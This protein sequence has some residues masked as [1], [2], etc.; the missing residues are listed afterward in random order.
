MD[1]EIEFKDKKI[2]VL[3]DKLKG[4][5]QYDEGKINEFLN[6]TVRQSDKRNRARRRLLEAMDNTDKTFK[7]LGVKTIIINSK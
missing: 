7:Q 1:E 4:L 2:T 6:H 5:D 3:E